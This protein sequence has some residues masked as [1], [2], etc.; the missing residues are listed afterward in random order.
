MIR[1]LAY[2]GFTSPAAPKW[3]SFGPDVLG[4]QVVAASDDEDGLVR[5]RIDDAAWRLAIHPGETNDVAYIGWDVG[6]APELAAAVDGLTRAGFDLVE[7]DPGLHEQRGVDGLAWFTD[8]FGFRHELTYGQRDGAEPFTPGRELDGGFVTGAG[9]M[10]HIV[11]M[12]PDFDAAND[13]FVDTLGFSH[14]DDVEMGVQVRFL[15]CNPR[16]H[17]LAFTA[18]PGMVGLHHL[19]LEVEQPNDVGRAYDIV[20]EKSLP[21]AMTLGRHTNDEMFSFYVRTPSGFEIE[22]G[23]GGRLMNLDEPEPAGLFDAQ[24]IWGHRPPEERL[25]PGILRKV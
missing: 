11:L 13:F 22:Y 9:G 2:L 19:M 4:A 18:V 3:T 15:H 12:V 14:S 8:P 21:L 1:S 6:G 24:S 10:G 23:S 17:T 7:G 20:N 5:L 25:F 16:H